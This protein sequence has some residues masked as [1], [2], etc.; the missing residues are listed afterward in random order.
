[1]TYRRSN[2]WWLV[3]A[4]VACAAVYLLGNDRTALWDRDEPW[5]AQCSR[6]MYQ[7]GDWV[8]PR[9]L[10][11]LR[12]EKPPLI[13]WLHMGA[14]RL[15]GDRP[16][17]PRFVSAASMTALLLVLGG[18]LWRF[19]GSSRA[20][21]TV[22]IFGSS[23]LTIA[24]AKMCLT[25]AF[26]LLCIIVSQLCLYAL[27]RGKGSW[28]I[29][30]LLWFGLAVGGMTK[31]PNALAPTITTALVLL[32]MD[33]PRCWKLFLP[34]TRRF[35]HGATLLL[36]A[37]MVGVVMLVAIA[38]PWLYL[39][40][41]REPQW[42]PAVMNIAAS[43]VQTPMEG[44]SGPP[45][46]YLLLVWATFFPWSLLLPM[47]AVYAW[48]NRHLPPV[49]FAIAAVLGPWIYQEIWKTKLPH[50][51]LPAYP[52]LAFLVADA[53]V[54]TLRSRGRD[55]TRPLFLRT[56]LGWGILISLLGSASW[57]AAIKFGSLPW[58]AM[59]GLSLLGIVYGMGTWWWF[60]RR[61]TA[62]A[63][64]W[65]GGGMLALV[66]LFYTAYAPNALY[67]RMSV[68]AAQVLRACGAVNP[69]D[70]LALDYREPSIAY[71]QGGTLRYGPTLET[72]NQLPQA[73]WPRWLVLSS[74][75]WSRFSPEK[76]GLYHP[77]GRFSGLNY[78]GDIEK[79]GQSARTR[80]I[81]LL[82]VQK[83]QSALP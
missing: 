69:G 33:L 41:Q 13:Y 38:G 34:W 11:N 49:R 4:I 82:V 5:Y 15:F 80:I 53:L 37:L 62:L 39:V 2:P 8:V 14:M 74:E 61:K 73:Q 54:R 46:Y 7:S 55:L 79:A 72:M 47:A 21:W 22:F 51:V 56:V 1:M 35:W 3:L 60:S 43:H 25:D 77:I 19:V 65:L 75:L 70:V 71:Y 26:M 17:S 20:I 6:Q 32:I 23:A 83:N 16:F 27:Y 18:A 28:E 9:F 36:I 29:L 12:T 57:L 59:A 44:H 64:A 31:G 45:G 42:L 48:K 76:Q 63:C 81:D 24:A 50:Y 52:A 68:Q 40:N 67:L 10:D 66:A 58:A 30:L 78:T